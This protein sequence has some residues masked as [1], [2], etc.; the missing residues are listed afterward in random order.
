MIITEKKPFQEIVNSL[1]DYKRIFLIGC[2]ECSTT[3]KTGGEEEVLAL[4]AELEKIGKEILG[5]AIPKAPC[6]SA[7]IKEALAKNINNLRQSEAILVLSCGLGVQSVKDNNRFD[8]KVVPGC[9][10]LFT[11]LVDAKGE[12]LEKCS[13]CGDCL[14]D[15]TEGI[16]PLTLCPKGL[17]NGPCG[18]MDKGKCEVDKDKDCAWVLIYKEMEKKD[19]LFKFQKTRSPRDFKNAV[20]PRRLRLAE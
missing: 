8:Q 14:L 2:G 1:K 13:L 19:R 15:F 20:R 10:T 4:K 5:F 7:Q 3:C 17:L 11:G 16:C 9:N 12:F 18:G 6:I